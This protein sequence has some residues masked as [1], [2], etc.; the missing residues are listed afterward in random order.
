M[1]AYVL[2]IA[3]A[4]LLS[5]VVTMIAPV[6]KMGKF[7]KGTTKLLI[8]VV[9]LSPLVSWVGSRSFT[10]RSAKI[11]TDQQYIDGCVSM[12]QARDEEEISAFLNTEFGVTA[13][14][15]TEREES[16]TFS[17]K[18]ITVNITDFGIYGQD[19]HINMISEIQGALE[20]KYGCLA[21]VS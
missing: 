6:G 16:G 15:Q 3:G 18:K 4:V 12:L 7:I 11:Q 17:L 2:A 8:L 9:M 21:E 5:A 19:V 20:E 1:K 14:V 10:F 13:V